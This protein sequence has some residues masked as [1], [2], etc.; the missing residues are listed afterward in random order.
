M[1]DIKKAGHWSSEHVMTSYVKDI[2]LGTCLARAGLD[3]RKDGMIHV[4]K[5][6]RVARE[7]YQEL[8]DMVFPGAREK[9]QQ[10]IKVLPH[11]VTN[12]ANVF[13]HHGEKCM[14]YS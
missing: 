8:A 6:G 2:P 3:P 10:R 7:P 1:D 4:L 14:C 13:R 11:T 5:R 12:S 9:L